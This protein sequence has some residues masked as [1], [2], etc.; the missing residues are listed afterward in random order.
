MRGDGLA[1]SRTGFLGRLANRTSALKTR[2]KRLPLDQAP[3]Q[4]ANGLETT[5]P[6]ACDVTE[7][8]DANPEALYSLHISGVRHAATLDSPDCLQAGDCR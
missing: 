4:Q 8:T 5:M 1:A 2:Q 6:T 3:D 7:I